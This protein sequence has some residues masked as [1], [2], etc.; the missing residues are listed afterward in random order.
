MNKTFTSLFSSS[1][2]EGVSSVMPRKET[3]ASLRLLARTFCGASEQELENARF[4][5]SALAGKAV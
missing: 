2:Q 3:I 1:Q 5:R 4:E